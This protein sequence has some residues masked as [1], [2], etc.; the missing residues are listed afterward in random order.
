MKRAYPIARLMDV[1]RLL[2]SSSDA[3]LQGMF[4]VAAAS[5]LP[6]R[7]RLGVKRLAKQ[8]QRGRDYQARAL[9]A[10]RKG[11]W[12]QAKD[13][14]REATDTLKAAPTGLRVKFAEP[15]LGSVD[16]GTWVIKAAR[17]SAKRTS[18]MIRAKRL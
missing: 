7:W 17:R 10:A 12:K 13:L 2:D 3:A 9:Q 1:A 11:H 18:D 14:I 16:L 8:V 5:H 15:A 4:R 6:D